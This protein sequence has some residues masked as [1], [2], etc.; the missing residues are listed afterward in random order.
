MISKII[1]GP[2]VF[3]IVNF[4]AF[5]IKNPKK[6]ALSATEKDP[7]IAM[8]LGPK[9]MGLKALGLPS[10]KLLNIKDK[11]T[12]T[13]LGDIDDMLYDM[14]NPNNEVKRSMNARSTY[15]ENYD[16]DP[17]YRDSSS[18]EFK[19]P[20]LGLFKRSATPE[21]EYSDYNFT[22]FREYKRAPIFTS[23]DS[24]EYNQN[25]ENFVDYDGYESG[26]GQRFD[27][28]DL[29]KMGG[30]QSKCGGHILK[31]DPS[32]NDGASGHDLFHQEDDPRFSDDQ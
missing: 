7:S 24:Y 14:M 6:Y 2:L 18:V 19:Q 13:L 11:E 29:A 28:L 15:Y 1:V 32:K 12:H 22:P 4:D 21:V 26:A 8:R 5:S 31:W 20:T 9:P 27:N 10:S 30:L 16:Y 17:Y 25:D 23:P 3:F